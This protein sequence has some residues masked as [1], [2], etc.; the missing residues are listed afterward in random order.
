MGYKQMQFYVTMMRVDEGELVVQR[1]KPGAA[2]E[3][4]CSATETGDKDDE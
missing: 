1:K 4:E 3:A 2:M